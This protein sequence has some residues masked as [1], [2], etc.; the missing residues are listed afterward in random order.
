MTA[1]P[2]ADTALDVFCLPERIDWWDPDAGCT[3]VMSQP[4]ADPALWMDYLEGAR[5]SY[6]K[7]GV[8]S[9]LHF[10]AIRGGEDTVL[11]WATLDA[12]GT[13]VGGVRAIGPLRSVDD[14]HAVVEWAGQPGLGAVRKM[15]S[16]R[17]P[18]GI[19]EMKSAWVSDDA[20]RN[21][22]LTHVL[23]RSGFHAMP[24]LGHQFCMATSAAHVL[25]RWG[26]SGGLV[27]SIPATH[28][29]DERYRTQM[30]WWDRRTFADHAQPEQVSKILQEMIT[31]ARRC[32][33]FVETSA[34]RQ[35]GP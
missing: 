12:S 28:Y 8:E 33:S 18:F 9:V 13:V 14:S 31:V 2:L 24:L 25:A 32:D 29:P 10:D 22:G 6:R 35:T 7:H 26:S 30:M 4:S 5:L 34:R 11:F 19:L 27:A 23:A 20:D 1:H 21:R 3:V 17:L 15:I 16:D